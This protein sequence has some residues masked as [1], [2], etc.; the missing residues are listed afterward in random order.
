MKNLSLMGGQ[1]SRSQMRNIS[2]G[3]NPTLEDGET[4]KC[5]YTCADGSEGYGP[6]CTTA[7]TIGCN[8]NGWVLCVGCDY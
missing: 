4:T 1:L 6:N 3:I 2:G 8:Y 5:F 7:P